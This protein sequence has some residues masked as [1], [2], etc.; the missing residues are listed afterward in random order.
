MFVAS[1]AFSYSF[2]HTDFIGPRPFGMHVISN[3]SDGSKKKVIYFDSSSSLM[4][5]P[6][7]RFAVGEFIIRFV[8]IVFNTSAI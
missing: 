1:I 3:N 7:R 5:T 4:C 8:F 6:V 2:P